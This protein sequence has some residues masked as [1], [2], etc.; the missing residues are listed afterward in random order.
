MKS[1]RRVGRPACLSP[2]PTN[3][4][5]PP[6]QQAKSGA[7]EGANP[8]GLYSSSAEKGIKS[9]QGA[10]AYGAIAGIRVRRQVCPFSSRHLP[11]N[12][13]DTKGFRKVADIDTRIFARAHNTF[14]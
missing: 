6:R 11:S 5:S 2:K 10:L 7:H 8:D 9:F 12:T 4:V 13:I 14:V 3:A 1:E